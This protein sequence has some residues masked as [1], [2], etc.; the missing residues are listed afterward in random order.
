MEKKF[1]NVSELTTRE[2]YDN[3]MSYVMQL[4]NNATAQGALSDPEADN[5]YIREIGRV[6]HL[7]AT[8][9][10]TRMEFKYIK[11]KKK[12]PLIKSIEDEMYARSINQ[13]ELA[14]ML[15]INEPELSLIIRGKRAISMR[16]AKK[17]HQSLHIDPKLIIDYA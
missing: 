16:I 6:G 7:C 15:S 4:I 13:K 2:E 11:V 9:E 12:S 10:D 14:K 3:A 1:E 17:L 5:E 8:Y